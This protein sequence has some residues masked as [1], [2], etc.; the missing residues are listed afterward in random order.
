[1][2]FATM[3]P[4]PNLT[5]YVK[6]IVG[7]LAI[8]GVTI[9]VTPIK[10][11][12]VSAAIRWVGRVMNKDIDEKIDRLDKKFSRHETDQLRRGILDFANSCMRGE[13]HTME[14]FDNI[15]H[16]YDDY[17]EILKCSNMENGR[18]E[19]TME[20]IKEVYRDCSRHDSFYRR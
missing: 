16:D 13:K 8:L 3:Q 18:I 7:I 4:I 14:E 9:E 2:M 5:E 11:N 6:T 15:F 17:E 1:M 10:I 20:Y 12:P 19:Q